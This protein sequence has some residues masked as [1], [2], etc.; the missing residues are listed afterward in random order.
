MSV[1]WIPSEISSYFYQIPQ[2]LLQ[3]N[4]SL[5]NRAIS[6]RVYYEKKFC[7]YLTLKKKI[8]Y[9]VKYLFFFIELLLLLNYR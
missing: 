3:D 8:I 2:G 1:K 6:Y 5:F 7:R 4:F 9:F